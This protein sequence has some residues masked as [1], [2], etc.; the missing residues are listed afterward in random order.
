MDTIIQRL[1]DKGID[2]NYLISICH[3]GTPE[4]AATVLRQIKEK[5]QQTELEILELSPALITHGGPGCIV[6]QA[7]KK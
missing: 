4:K 6:V 2:E 7:I 1:H 3:A 5:F